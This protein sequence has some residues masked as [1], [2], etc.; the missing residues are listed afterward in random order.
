M[1]TG[2][3]LSFEVTPNR[4]RDDELELAVFYDARVVSS[5]EVDE[6][7]GSVGRVLEWMTVAPCTE[8]GKLH[9]A[10]LGQAWE[11][12]RPVQPDGEAHDGVSQAELAKLVSAVRVAWAATLRL[13]G[14][15]VGVDD[16]F[17]SLG[18]DSVRLR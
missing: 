15:D 5:G 6:V 16:T 11:I 12:R 10:E 18:G 17:A 1:P 14:E 3:S 8:V 9:L 7:V 4:A 2:Y 13:D